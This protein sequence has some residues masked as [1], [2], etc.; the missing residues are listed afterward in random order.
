[1]GQY[2]YSG[3][4]TDLRNNE[5][6]KKNRHT[7]KFSFTYKLFSTTSPVNSK[8][9]IYKKKHNSISTISQNLLLCILVECSKFSTIIMIILNNTYHQHY[10]QH[11]HHHHYPGKCWKQCNQSNSN[12][13]KY[14]E[15]SNKVQNALV[16]HTIMNT[17]ILEGHQSSQA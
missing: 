2:L 6:F 8:Y 13:I 15:I 10:H 17:P 3:Y 4:H 11:H 9:A 12:I 16:H 7:N 14:C 5:K 1:M